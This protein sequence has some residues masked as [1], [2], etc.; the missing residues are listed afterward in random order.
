MDLDDVERSNLPDDPVQTATVLQDGMRNADAG[1]N[2]VWEYRFPDGRVVTVVNMIYN[3]RVIVGDGRMADAGWCY[4]KNIGTVLCAVAWVLEDCE[5]EP[6][7]W[8]KN[9]QTG[10]LRQ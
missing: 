6:E 7:G 3:M 1:R 8:F 2:I 4:H 9:L 10:E 5:G